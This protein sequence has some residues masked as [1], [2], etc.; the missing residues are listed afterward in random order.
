[1]EF[2]EL[3]FQIGRTP[4]GRS[5]E[6]Y[7]RFHVFAR[8]IH[9]TMSVNRNLNPC[10]RFVFSWPVRGRLLNRA[11]H[12]IHKQFADDPAAFLALGVLVS[13]MPVLANVLDE[14]FRDDEFFLA[15]SF[16]S[17][18]RSFN[19]DTSDADHRG[20]VQGAENQDAA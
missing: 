20:F 17:R 13:L 16:P 1:M 10:A 18:L 7:F 8:H 15:F 3:F 14:G 2:G 4:I 6:S 5:N 11:F 19:L 9:R 12:C